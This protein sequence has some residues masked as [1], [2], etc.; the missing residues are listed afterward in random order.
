MSEFCENRY[1]D[2]V[3]RLQ[4]VSHS[5]YRFAKIVKSKNCGMK[6][7]KDC[8]NNF[9]KSGCAQIMCAT[10]MYDAL[11]CCFIFYFSQIEILKNIL[12][13]NKKR[14]IDKPRFKGYYK[15]A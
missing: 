15:I 3:F 12:I 10:K 14:G 7:S 11:L 2:K 9:E 6:Q 1:F 4:A 5:A 13:K 8:L